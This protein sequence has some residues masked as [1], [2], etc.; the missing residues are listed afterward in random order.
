M[1]TARYA[2]A[3]GAAFATDAGEACAALWNPHASLSL[4]VVWAGIG[5]LNALVGGTFRL[6]RISSRGTAGATVTP[7]ADNAF[8]RHAVPPSGALLDVGNYTVAPTEAGPEIWRFRYI[9]G[10]NSY[11][12]RAYPNKRKHYPVEVPAGTGLCWFCDVALVNGLACFRWD[13]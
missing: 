1:T 8:D 12:S 7:D 2:V 4:Y 6:S 3:S 13:E 10:A 9:E 11:V 5:H